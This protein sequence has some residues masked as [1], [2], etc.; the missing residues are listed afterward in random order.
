MQQ[1][2]IA[3]SQQFRRAETQRAKTTTTKLTIHDNGNLVT[4]NQW[5]EEDSE[6]LHQ[7]SKL[8]NFSAVEVKEARRILYSLFQQQHHLA[9][10]QLIRKAKR[11]PRN[12]NL[13]SLSPFFKDES[14]LNRVEGRLANSPYD[15]DKKFPVLIPR[16]LPINKLL[17]REAHERSFHSGPQMTLYT[18]RQT[19]WI[20][21]GLALVKQ[22]IHNCKPCIRQDASLLQ[23]E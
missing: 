19:V 21:G 12:S 11:I 5:N 18:L 8:E 17:I 4:F 22:A 16:K 15:I 1:S 6:E 7:L 10:F 14:N 13:L 23:P 20:P 2:L 3:R 9:E